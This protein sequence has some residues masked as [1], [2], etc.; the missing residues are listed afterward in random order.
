[1][2]HF[3]GIGGPNFS[4]PTGPNGNK[5]LGQSSAPSNLPTTGGINNGPQFGDQVSFSNGLPVANTNQGHN[6]NFNEISNMTMQ[7]ARQQLHG[8]TFGA[9]SQLF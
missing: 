6:V 8:T 4:G 3:R 2:T 5:P 9:M 1:M 7:Q